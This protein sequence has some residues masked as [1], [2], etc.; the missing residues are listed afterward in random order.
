MR[1]LMVLPWVILLGIAVAGGVSWAW[2]LEIQEWRASYQ[3][4]EAQ[5]RAW[6]A[7]T[8]IQQTKAAQFRE[9]AESNATTAKRNSEEVAAG[10]ERIVA[11]QVAAIEQEGVIGSQLATINKYSTPAPT[12][13]IPPTYTRYPTATPRPT[14]TRYPTSTPRPTY[15]RRP[16]PRPT[17]RIWIPTATSIW[18]IPTRRPTRVPTATPAPDYFYV[19][20]PIVIYEGIKVYNDSNGEGRGFITTRSC[21]HY[22]VTAAHVVDGNRRIYIEHPPGSSNIGWKPIYRQNLSKDIALVDIT[23]EYPFA[24]CGDGFWEESL[25][26]VLSDGVIRGFDSS[27]GFDRGGCPLSNADVI[28][29]SARSHPGYSGAPVGLLDSDSLIGMHVCVEENNRFGIAISWAEIE[30]VLP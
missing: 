9:L 22:L 16:T 20:D 6:Q 23:D 18:N 5:T 30:D 2:L 28:R 13:T 24:G 29:H 8:D 14:Y 3:D 25:G 7:R 19:N 4:Q 21:K 15:T 11:L 26:G 1:F 10:N 17:Y 27:F 12:Y